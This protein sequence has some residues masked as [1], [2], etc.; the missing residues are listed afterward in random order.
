MPLLRILIT[1][2]WLKGRS[3]TEIVTMDMACGFMRRGHE[4][5]VFSPDLGESA[6]ALR[7]EGARVTDRLDDLDFRPDVVHGNHAVDLVHGLIAFPHAPGVF[8]CHNPEHWI[9]SPPDMSRIRAFVSVDRLGQ[10]RIARELPRT[11]G[12]VH[13]VHNAVDLQR[14][15]PRGPL[16]PRPAKAMMLTKFSTGISEVRAACEAAGIEIDVVGTG[17]GTVVDDLPKRLR[18][19][20]IVFASARM[21]IEAMAVGC[22]VVVMD[23]RGLAGLATEEAFAVWR[24]ENFGRTALTRPVTVEVL[25]REIAKYDTIEAARVAEHVRANHGLDRALSIY[26]EIYRNAIANN[27]KIDAHEEARELSRLMRHWLPT[28]DGEPAIGM[29][30]QRSGDPHGVI[31]NRVM[32]E[33]LKR[34]EADGLAR[35]EQIH[36]LHR[37]LENSERDRAARLA[38]IQQLDGDAT[39]LR[40]EVERLNLALNS[41][42]TLLRRFAAL[43]MQQIRVPPSG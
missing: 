22:A 16:P 21:A 2:I 13:L 39:H 28:I 18:S 11:R 20:D 4:V 27:G 17:V 7:R 38:A 32:T 31:T 15:T 30:V 24:D 34:S 10:E 19:A 35:L 36:T 29:D 41:P 8:V 23:G 6:H 37:L 43:V 12:H 25:A 33:A 3:G 9:C 14:F 26:E 40:N 42:K 1:N 5:V